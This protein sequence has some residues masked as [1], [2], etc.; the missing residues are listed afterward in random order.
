MS[1]LHVQS[2]DEFLPHPV[3][4]DGT[5]LQLYITTPNLYWTLKMYQIHIHFT[6][7]ISLSNSS[8]MGR[9]YYAHFTA[10]ETDRS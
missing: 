1:V 5:N 6:C 8:S 2:S 10:K 7:I 9:H 3:T 4:T